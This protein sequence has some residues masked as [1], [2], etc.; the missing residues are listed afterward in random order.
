MLLI[1]LN[2]SIVVTTWKAS[3]LNSV[4]GN[5]IVDDFILISENPF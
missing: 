5:I 3:D 1:L 4:H 2:Y